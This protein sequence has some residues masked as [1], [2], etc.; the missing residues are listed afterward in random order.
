MTDAHLLA[1]PETARMDPDALQRVEDLFREQIEQGVHP[2]AGLA[3]Y[4]QGNLVLDLYGGVADAKSGKPGTADT[5]FV[6]YSC[7]RPLTAPAGRPSGA[8]MGG[9]A[10]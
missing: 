10:K 3:V 9:I 7:T 6:L 8:G 5:M 2:G 1:T 4:R